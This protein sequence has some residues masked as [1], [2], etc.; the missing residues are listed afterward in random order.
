MVKLS[1]MVEK[2]YLV[3]VDPYEVFLT[4]ANSLL[5]LFSYWLETKDF[6]P[7]NPQHHQPPKN[8]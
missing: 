8:I 3:I 1:K 5:T 6:Q 2:S 4:C 7:S